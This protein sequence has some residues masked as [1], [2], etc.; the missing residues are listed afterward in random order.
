MTGRA[1][2]AAYA[3]RS[4][5]SAPEPPRLVT[6][7]EAAVPYAVAARDLLRNTLLDAM[8]RELATRPWAEISMVDVARAAGISRQTLYKEFGSRQDFA[9]AY[10]L[11]EADSFVEAVE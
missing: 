7:A 5:S 10:V 3:T 1:P 11:R 9:R 6:V 8:R 4:T 2:T